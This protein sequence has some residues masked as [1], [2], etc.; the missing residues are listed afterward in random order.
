MLQEIL[1]HTAYLVGVQAVA[2]TDKSVI[3]LIRT[4]HGNIAN[5]GF[6]QMIKEEQTD[7]L[8]E[9]KLQRAGICIV[10]KNVFGVLSYF[11]PQG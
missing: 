3:R 9:A 7:V 2:K 6:W 8:D 4:N 5:M 1:L 11:L 10:Q